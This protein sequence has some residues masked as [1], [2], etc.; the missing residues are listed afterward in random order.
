[1]NSALR[2]AQIG[3]SLLWVAMVCLRLAREPADSAEPWREVPPRR[4]QR[5]A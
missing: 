1:V 3:L 2:D 5:A 4:W